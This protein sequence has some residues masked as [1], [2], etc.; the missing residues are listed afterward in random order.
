MV[1]KCLE[2]DYNAFRALDKT[3]AKSKEQRLEMLS[4][5]RPEGSKSAVDLF[6]WLVEVILCQAYTA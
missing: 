3:K 2:K 4:E 1:P 6:L 5:C